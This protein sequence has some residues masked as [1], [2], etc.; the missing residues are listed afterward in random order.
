MSGFT[1]E[2]SQ[3]LELS[4]VKRLL[5]RLHEQVAVDNQRIEIKRHD[6]D[7][8]CVIISRAELQALEQAL[9]ILSE[10]DAYKATAQTL[11][12]LAAATCDGY[13]HAQP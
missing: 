13:A 4:E 10:S 8:V 3:S 12:E 6:F 11:T 5:G 1:G 7:D 2:F 9:E